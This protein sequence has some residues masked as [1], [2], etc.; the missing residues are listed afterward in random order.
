M[1]LISTSE[2]CSLCI[3]LNMVNPPATA[4]KHQEFK[5]HMS[6]NVCYL[7]PTPKANFDKFCGVIKAISFHTQAVML[8]KSVYG[9]YSDSN[10]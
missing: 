4:S 6:P 1:L 9:C 2:I 5:R 3:F 8:H 7:F 10:V